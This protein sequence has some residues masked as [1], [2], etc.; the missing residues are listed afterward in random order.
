MGDYVNTAS[1][2]RTPVVRPA[3]KRGVVSRDAVSRKGVAKY[4]KPGRPKKR[5][6]A[7]KRGAGS[8]SEL[9][10]RTGHPVFT[11]CVTITSDGS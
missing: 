7:Q 5:K 11:T 8:N 3:K 1:C 6:F 10:T 4:T 2:P 9:D